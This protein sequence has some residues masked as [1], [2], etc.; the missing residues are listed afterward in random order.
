[1]GE[2]IWGKC[3]CCSLLS[4]GASTNNSRELQITYSFEGLGWGVGVWR[5][6]GLGASH[7]RT[8]QVTSVWDWWQGC[9]ERPR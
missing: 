3:F 8:S 7:H 5:A 2:Q 6:T 4:L 9:A 1:M